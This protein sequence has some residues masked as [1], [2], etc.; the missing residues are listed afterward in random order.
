[1][2]LGS[3]GVAQAGNAVEPGINVVA[4]V[5]GGESLCFNGR[6]NGGIANSLCEVDA[7]HGVARES[8]GANLRLHGS[9]SEV[10]ESETGLCCCG[11]GE[12]RKSLFSY[13]IFTQRRPLFTAADPSRT[14]VRILKR[15]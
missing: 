12:A 3:D 7:A 15:R 1:M 4:R 9:G 6:R 8:H 13:L 11:H 14:K 2:L 10:A 5:N